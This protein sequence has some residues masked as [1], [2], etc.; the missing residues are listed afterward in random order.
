MRNNHPA[1]QQLHYGNHNN[2]TYI[3]DHADTNRLPHHDCINHYNITGQVATTV[4]SYE[5]ITMTMT[6]EKALYTTMVKTTQTATT[7]IIDTKTVTILNEKTTTITTSLS[8][9]AS[10]PLYIGLVTIA[11]L[12]MTSYYAIK[13]FR[14]F[15]QNI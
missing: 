15:G 11:V 13:R 8:Y 12:S 5:T 1:D 4:T 6:P 14:P 9:N 10:I 2:H 7:S 3:G